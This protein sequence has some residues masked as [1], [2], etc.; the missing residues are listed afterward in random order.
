MKLLDML[1]KKQL[2]S[3]ADDISNC[4]DD[5]RNINYRLVNLKKSA[6]DLNCGVTIDIVKKDLINHIN[7]FAKKVHDKSIS[8]SLSYAPLNE[9]Y[10]YRDIF[11]QD[12]NKYID[13][14]FDSL[15]IKNDTNK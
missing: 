12:T 9:L 8:I 14:I 15:Q 5:I 11:F 10:S 1:F 3:V 4:E 7:E 2:K 13:E 6:E